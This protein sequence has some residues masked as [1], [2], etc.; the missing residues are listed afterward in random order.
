MQKV[1]DFSGFWG[2]LEP[3]RNRSEQFLRHFRA[4][5]WCV[6]FSIWG[7]SHGIIEETKHDLN[8][9]NSLLKILQLIET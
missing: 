6:S 2:N 8:N 3:K 7:K 5:V 4:H 9:W 1:T